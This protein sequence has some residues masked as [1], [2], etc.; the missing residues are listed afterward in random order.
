M[1]VTRPRRPSRL[2]SARSSIIMQYGL[3]SPAASLEY[4]PQQGQRVSGDHLLFVSRNDIGLES[5]AGA[6]DQRPVPLVAVRVELEAEPA[7]TLH[8]PSSYR[9][10]ALADARGKH[11]AVDPAHGG[12]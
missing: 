5:A 4:G 9:R 8:D 10:T 2:T 7:Q 11:D 1:P 12:R 3:L 6:G